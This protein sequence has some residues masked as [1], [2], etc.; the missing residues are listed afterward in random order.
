MKRFHSTS[1]LGDREEYEDRPMPAGKRVKYNMSNYSTVDFSPP[2]APSYHFRSSSSTTSPSSRVYN[3]CFSDRQDR[4]DDMAEGKEDEEEGKYEGEGG[5]EVEEDEEGSM[6]SSPIASRN[7]SSNKKYI[8]EYFDL[9]TRGR[10]ASSSSS[11]SSMEQDLAVAGAA[12]VAVAVAVCGSCSAELE[13]DDLMQEHEACCYFCN[14]RGCR[15][16]VEKCIV[17]QDRFCSNCSVDVYSYSYS[18]ERICSDCN[19]DNPTGGGIRCH[20]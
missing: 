13:E 12:S 4:A 10:L 15:H 2:P 8:N 3:S 5:K 16:C 6:I 11:S 18:D 19:C 20:R 7:T 9:G 17:C 1:Q 14:T